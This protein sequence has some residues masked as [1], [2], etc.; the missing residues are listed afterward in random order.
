M[1]NV[2]LVSNLMLLREGAKRILSP[3]EGIDVI[4]EIEY[5]R[6]VLSNKKLAQ[7][8]VLV[9]IADAATMEGSEQLIHLRRE[10]PSLHVMILLRF[11][12]LHQVLAILRSGVRGLLSADSSATQL[13]AAI[14]TI[15]SGRLYLNEELTRLLIPDFEEIGKDYTHKA[16]SQRE[17]E[18][19]L[20]LAAG[21]KVTEIAGQLGIS[22]KT[23]STHKTRL[24]EKMR[25]TT[26]SQI[27]QYAIA[28]GL[29]ES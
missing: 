14:R 8:D 6:D 22:I 5:L 2:V 1:I 17:L 19:F 20:R 13:P 7:A 24:M 16:L 18:V 9:V 27:V 26:F 11:P 21:N 15:S 25:M 3:Q 23:V 29:Y 10:H 4:A 28:Y 12:T